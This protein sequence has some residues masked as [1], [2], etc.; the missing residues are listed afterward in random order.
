MLRWWMRM[1]I[2]WSEIDLSTGE[3]QCQ[4]AHDDHEDDAEVPGDVLDEVQC[5]V[6]QDEW[7]C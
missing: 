3:E 7:I 2:E 6:E 1:M 5:C 4:V